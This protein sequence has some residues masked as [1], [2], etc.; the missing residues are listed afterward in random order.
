MGPAHWEVAGEDLVEAL[1]ELSLNE[2]NKGIHHVLLHRC[3]CSKTIVYFFCR[4]Q[5]RCKLKY[6]RMEILGTEQDHHHDKPLI[7][8]LLCRLPAD[9]GR[10]ELLFHQICCVL[11]GVH[12]VGVQRG[13]PSSG[14][15]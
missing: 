2:L 12:S 15:R 13:V 4:C 6:C 7:Q 9:S 14:G 10:D 5:E 8:H 11:V 3:L 1:D